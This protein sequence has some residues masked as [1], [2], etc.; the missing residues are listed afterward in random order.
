[1]I[2]GCGSTAKDLQGGQFGHFSSPATPSA[3]IPELAAVQGRVEGYLFRI[4]PV[5]IVDDPANAPK[6]SVPVSGGMVVASQPDGKMSGMAVTRNDGFFS[7]TGLPAGTIHLA[8]YTN[9][10]GAPNVTTD[11]TVIARA[12]V[13]PNA[14]Y[15]VPR[16]SAVDTVLQLAPKSA[17]V[18]ATMTPLP[19]GARLEN[20]LDE[21]V[22]SPTSSFKGQTLREPTWLIFVDPSPVA[23]YAHPVEYY[24]VS[25][26]DGTVTKVQADSYP[27]VNGSAFWVGLNE[28][29]DTSDFEPGERFPVGFVPKPGPDVVSFPPDL[30]DSPED[31][32]SLQATSDP[33]DVVAVSIS[34]YDDY[35]SHRSAR[36]FSNFLRQEGVP[37]SQIFRYFAVD[38]PIDGTDLLDAF[39]GLV[40]PDRSQDVEAGFNNALLRANLKVLERKRLGLSSTLIFFVNAH[41]HGTGLFQLGRSKSYIFAPQLLGGRGT[42]SRYRFLENSL[43]CQVRFIF[44]TCQSGGIVKNC[45]AHVEKVRRLSPRSDFLFSDRFV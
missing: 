38:G 6:G 21:A 20:G 1:M 13:V 18:R 27:R 33:T 22:G 11:V 32:P 5:L 10:G 42:T 43:A 25:A 44:N 29:F 19:S 30:F 3:S 37:D 17:L 35:H 36:M 23:G 24:L 12:Q 34:G 2:F 4:N 8:G 9:P 26:S 31:L 14:K 41:G 7:L 39:L 15:P 40:P 16:Q 28:S 45:S